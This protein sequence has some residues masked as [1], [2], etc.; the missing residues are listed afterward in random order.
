MTLERWPVR[1]SGGALEQLR[2]R[3]VSENYFTV[4]G[5]EPARGRVFTEQDATGVGKDPYAVISYDYWQRRF[6]GNPSVL[7]TPIRL[8]QATLTIIGIAPKDFHGETVG[9][10]PDLWL[11]LLMQPL[12]MP[13]IDAFSEYFQ[14]HDKLMWLHAFG[15]RKAGVPLSQVQAEMNVL[16]R[17][18][19]AAGY[20]GP[21]RRRSAGVRST[22]TLS[23]GLSDQACFTAAP[24]FPHNGPCSPHWPVL[25]SSSPVRT[26]PTCCSPARPHALVK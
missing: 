17:G 26:S 3:L 19:L 25:F 10:N 9:Q 18:I 4:F 12:V 20:Q 1:I 22:S 6:G 5:V 11:P 21:W 16:F 14:A 2:G 8:H 7:G 13:G 24:N 23:S 15:R